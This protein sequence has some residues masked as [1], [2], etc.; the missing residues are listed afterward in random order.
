MQHSGGRE[1]PCIIVQ[2]NFNLVSS[3]PDNYADG[4]L[5][6]GT[7]HKEDTYLSW[8]SFLLLRWLSLNP[9][10]TCFL[11]V[12]PG[13]I[14]VSVFLVRIRWGIIRVIQAG[15]SSCKGIIAKK[16]ENMD[17][18]AA[19]LLVSFKFTCANDVYYLKVLFY[20][21]IVCSVVYFYWYI[22]SIEDGF[23]MNCH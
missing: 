3:V 6:H 17:F 5:F 13:G 14:P 11:P 10:F 2:L 15:F 1:W 12:L 20:N 4:G 19:K 18:T 9:T 7:L 16:R 22:R 21:Y 23:K 8:F